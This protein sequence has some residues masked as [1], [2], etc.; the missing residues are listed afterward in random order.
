MTGGAY[1]KCQT[2]IQEALRL[3]NGRIVSVGYTE[4]AARRL[5]CWLYGP[6]K[7]EALGLKNKA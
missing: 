4:A 7:K 1:D 6:K 2:F 3:F 5:K